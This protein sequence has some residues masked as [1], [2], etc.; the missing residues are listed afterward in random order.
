[1]SSAVNV[2]EAP[3]NNWFANESFVICN[4]KCVTRFANAFALLK[5]NS[6]TM[7]ELENV[8]EKRKSE[9]INEFV[10]VFEKRKSGSNYKNKR[11]IVANK[12]ICF[13]NAIIITVH[14]SVSK[15]KNQLIG[16]RFE[17]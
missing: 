5:R 17:Q 4:G 3:L 2:N 1:M 8:V 11:V 16:I 14:D 9:A 13:F 7:N 6:E 15:K 12:I 10:N